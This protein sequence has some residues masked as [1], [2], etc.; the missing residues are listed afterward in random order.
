MSFLDTL[1]YY[2]KKA[3]DALGITSDKDS[4]PAKTP[5]KKPSSNTIFSTS[6]EGKNSN[7]DTFNKSNPR[8]VQQITAKKTAKKSKTQ[9]KN[10]KN[11][12]VNKKENFSKEIKQIHSRIKKMCEENGLKAKDIIKN[13]ENMSGINKKDY[14]KLTER[15]KIKLW[16]GIET[17]ISEQIQI[18]KKY[19]T[20]AEA[21]QEALLLQMA[22]TYMEA[23]EN[24]EIQDG[25]T[26]FDEAGDINEELGNDFNKKSKAEQK[27]KIN[28]SYKRW[29]QYRQEKVNEAIKNCKSEKEKAAKIKEINEY[30][31][32]IELVRYGQ[33]LT[34]QDS[35]EG[36][37]GITLMGPKNM[38]KGLKMYRAT[39]KDD[40]ERRRVA[41]EII[42]FDSE[43]EIIETYSKRGEKADAEAVKEFNQY[44]VMDKSAEKLQEFQ[45]DYVEA[46]KSGQYAF[47][48]ED[49]IF[50]AMATGIGIGATVNTCMTEDEKAA[51]LHNWN[52]DAQQFDDYKEVIKAVEEGVQAYIEEHAEDRPEL[53]AEVERIREI[54]KSL[55]KGK[56]STP[57]TNTGKSNN[58]GSKDDFETRENSNNKNYY[59][60]VSEEKYTTVPVQ[61]NKS[62]EQQTV[63][64]KQK[65]TPEEIRQ[66]LKNQPYSEAAKTYSE[67]DLAYTILKYGM[68]EHLYYVNNYIKRCNVEQLEELV[69]GCSTS[70]FLYVLRNISPDKASKLYDSKDDLC[71]AARTLGEKI[72]EESGNNY[73]VA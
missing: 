71:Y 72:I 55:P 14:K 37:N 15:E 59:Q 66:V 11:K 10:V 34:T 60:T 13:L 57:S 53:A 30:L 8:K 69:Q 42:T 56:V 52:I 26:F 70:G 33:F 61:I 65:A 7:I 49:G 4:K 5:A 40:A 41:D 62:S 67:K 64:I 1:S 22:E 54:E 9:Q 63:K 24:G 32:Q 6:Q 20:S 43:L 29:Q 25:K 68:K 51:F 46:R 44:G 12:Q 3:G 50:T 45:N 2:A 35:E 19:G 36:Y 18:M 17:I 73:E 48:E 38:G 28:E 39:R 27:R 47:L 16:R 21:S 23:L 31:D 58:N